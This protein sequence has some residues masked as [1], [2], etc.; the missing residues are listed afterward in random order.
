[1]ARIID[2]YE[3]IE[4]SDPASWRAWLAAQHTASPG[5]WLVLYKKA[6]GRQGRLTYAAAVEEALCFG[7]IDSLPRLK[8]DTCFHLLFTPRK[9]RSVW[10]KLNKQRIEKLLADGRM[11][12]AGLRKIEAA[13]QDG[14]WDTLNA[15]DALEMP[16]S[17][18]AALAANP[19][20]EQHFNAFAP[21]TKRQALQYLYS[22]KRPE[23]Q[24]K[25]VE[26]IVALA[27]QNKK[28]NQ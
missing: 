12:P 8:D 6:S 15:S 18:A 17:L 16:P 4:A 26:Q 22:A 28:L 23:T 7:W 24:Q 10:S 19:V 21:S 9:P 20:A 1:M 5:A 14:S 27:A 13:R 3:T 2:S 25:R 11:T